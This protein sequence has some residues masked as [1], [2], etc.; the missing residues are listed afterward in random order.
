[1]QDEELEPTGLAGLLEPGVLGR[2][3]LVLALEGV[4]RPLVEGVEGRDE[5]VLGR[6]GV[7]EGEEGVGDAG[8]GLDGVCCSE[9]LAGETAFSAVDFGRAHGPLFLGGRPNKTLT[10]K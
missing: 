9:D 4:F 10:W 3:L 2:E 8:G 5:G 7:L 6:E 1:M